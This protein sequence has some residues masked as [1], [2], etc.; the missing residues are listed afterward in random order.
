MNGIS[1]PRITVIYY[2]KPVD[3]ELIPGCRRVSLNTLDTIDTL[4]LK[5]YYDSRDTLFFRLD[6]SLDFT[7]QEVDFMAGRLEELIRRI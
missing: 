3:R 7:K 2:D 1:L 5:V 4:M 6:T